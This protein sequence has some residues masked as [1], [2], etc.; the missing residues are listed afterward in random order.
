MYEAYKNEL[1]EL[2]NPENDWFNEYLYYNYDG[3]STTVYDD[4]LK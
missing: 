3:S 2:D 1:Y 4:Y